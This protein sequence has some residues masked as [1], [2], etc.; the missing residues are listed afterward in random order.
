M[1]T[2]SGGV[3]ETHRV[4]FFHNEYEMVRRGREPSV[5]D[6]FPVTFIN[7]PFVCYPFFTVPELHIE[8]DVLDRYEPPISQDFAIKDE[9]GELRDLP[10]HPQMPV[11]P[12][13]DNIAFEHLAGAL[14]V[15]VAAG[16]EEVHTPFLVGKVRDNSCFDR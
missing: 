16:G 14:A 15:N 10:A 4:R 3:C 6:D 13:F 2:A 5:G 9:A 11:L 8:C 12:I 1:E 7:H